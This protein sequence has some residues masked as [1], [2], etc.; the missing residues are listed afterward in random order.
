MFSFILIKSLQRSQEAAIPRDLTPSQ[1]AQS[2]EYAL[3]KNQAP[4]CLFWAFFHT[5]HS[6]CKELGEKPL[7][8]TWSLSPYCAE[9]TQYYAKHTYFAESNFLQLHEKNPNKITHIIVMGFPHYRTKW[10][11]GKHNQ[12]TKFWCFVF[13]FTEC[14]HI[15]GD[16]NILHLKC[17]WLKLY[18]WNTVP[19]FPILFHGKDRQNYF[20]LISG[21]QNPR[22]SPFSIYQKPL[23]DIQVL[24]YRFLVI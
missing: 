23:D 18:I 15:F 19:L 22:Q 8:C 6:W 24:Y 14:F 3:F 5:I 2:A 12:G 13:S 1:S 4:C 9:D 11:N 21:W 10:C 7:K 16:N 17:Y 20:T